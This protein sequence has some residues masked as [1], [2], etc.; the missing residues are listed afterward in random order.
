MSILEILLGAV[1]IWAIIANIRGDYPSSRMKVSRPVSISEIVFIK[2]EKIDD[3]YYLWNKDTEDFL[4]QG[5]TIEKALQALMMRYPN[6]TFK[7]E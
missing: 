3:N 6:T 7:N 5:P 2:I 4:A 1:L